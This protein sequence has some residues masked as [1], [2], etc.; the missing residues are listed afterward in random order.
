MRRMPRRRFLRRHRLQVALAAPSLVAV[1]LIVLGGEL[2]APARAAQ[3]E[4]SAEELF[5]PF[6]GAELSQWLVG[7]IARLATEDEI[8]AYLRLKTDDDARRF[9]GEFW[10]KRDAD[11]A[12]PGNPALELYEERA[13]EADKKF[14][15]AA[16]AGRRTDRGTIHILYGEP[17]SVEYEE[18]QDVSGP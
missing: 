14:S 4:H 1:A 18:F 6:L 12:Q 11:P 3:K 5:Q 9:I 16:V 10:A 7:P 15:E 13:A 17:E 2:A 8:E